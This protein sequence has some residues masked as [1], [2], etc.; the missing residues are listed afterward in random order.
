M[1]VTGEPVTVT[2]VTTA[3][4][5][6]VALVTVKVPVAAPG[7]VNQTLMVQLPPA[8]V[9]AAAHVPG[10]AENG[11]VTVRLALVIASIGIPLAGLLRVTATG[12][13]TS[14]KPKLAGAD[15]MAA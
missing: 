14:A 2:G 6:L 11:P 9:A 5:V 3:P 1:R 13:F 4:V 7:A 10:V 15:S 8:G 12:T